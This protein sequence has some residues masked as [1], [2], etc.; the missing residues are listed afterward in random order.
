MTGE[1][2]GCV[3]FLEVR[4]VVVMVRPLPRPNVEYLE[5]INSCLVLVHLILPFAFSLQVH[6]RGRG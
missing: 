6:S 4:L 1:K 3:F 2:A 5:Q